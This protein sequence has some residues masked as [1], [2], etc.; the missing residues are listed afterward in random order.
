MNKRARMSAEEFDSQLHKLNKI[1]P[2]TTSLARLVLVD[3]LNHA[4]AAN[5]AGG[6]RQN[7]AKAVDR[8]LAIFKDLPPDYVPFNEMVPQSMATEMRKRL[9]VLAEQ[10]KAAHEKKA[11]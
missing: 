11:P 5:I 3:G 7:V 8:V 1:T 2:Q 9:A 10:R 6:S 4:Q